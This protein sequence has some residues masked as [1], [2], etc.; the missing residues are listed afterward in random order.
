M[1]NL[2]SVGLNVENHKIHLLSPSLSV[3]AVPLCFGAV[4]G[5]W[6][7]CFI[8]RGKALWRQAHT[9]AGTELCI[10]LILVNFERKK[11]GLKYE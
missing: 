7:V 1:Y 10:F 9:E 4:W 2:A 6:A 11:G 3:F 5:A 8:D